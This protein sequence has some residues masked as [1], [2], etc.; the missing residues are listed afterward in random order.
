MDLSPFAFIALVFMLPSFL[1]GF[2]FRGASHHDSSKTWTGKPVNL[3][4]DL[5]AICFA[6]HSA[7]TVKGQPASE[8]DLLGI[9]G[10]D[11]DAL[12]P[13]SES[14]PSA[15]V[16]VDVEKAALI[17]RQKAALVADA[18]QITQTQLDLSNGVPPRGGSARR[19]LDAVRLAAGV[20]AKPATRY[21]YLT[22]FSPAFEAALDKKRAAQWGGR[23]TLTSA[24]EGAI[25][26]RVFDEICGEI[27]ERLGLES[28]HG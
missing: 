8:P 5:P 17:A 11:A 3:A 22:M 26:L 1:A 14:N 25:R 9:L 21:L 23:Q 16:G 19:Y 4:E 27:W 6:A 12:G 18:L 20:L 10:L 2:L 24:E 28:L 15:G 7:L 13:P